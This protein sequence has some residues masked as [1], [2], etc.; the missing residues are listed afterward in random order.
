MLTVV[1]SRPITL[2]ERPSIA[3]FAINITGMKYKIRLIDALMNTRR[4]TGI[5]EQADA[6][7][8]SHHRQ[9]KK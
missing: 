8:V 2:L 6:I 3:T 7:S 1:G 9:D 4:N 5:Y